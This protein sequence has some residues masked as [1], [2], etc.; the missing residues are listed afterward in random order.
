MKTASLRLSG[1]TALV[2]GAAGFIGSHLCER[3]LSLGSRVTGVDNFDDY[4]SPELKKSNASLLQANST[5]RMV[6]A[7]IRDRA[8]MAVLFESEN[9]DFVFHL[10]ARAGVR[11]SIEH[12][13]LYADVNVT[14]TAVMLDL[15]AKAKVGHFVLASSSSVYG[16]QKKTPYSES[17]D[18]RQPIS[19]YA[20]TK[21]S[22]ELLGAT[23]QH[24][25]GLNVSC[26]RYFTVYGP[27]QRPE[28]A[29][30]KFTRCIIEGKPIDVFAQGELCRDFT[31]IEDIVTGTTRIAERPDGYQIVN[32]G[33]SQ[34]ESVNSL[35]SILEDI[36][37]RDAIRNELPMQP[38]DVEQTFADISKARSEYGYE[39]TTPLGFGVAKY[40]EW[41]QQN[42]FEEVADSD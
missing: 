20:A 26:L 10:A 33:N 25:Y 36:L 12:P 30:A 1:S 31:Y 42:L 3:L 11:P 28:M 7:D 35:I 24:L 39:P 4:Y 34:S 15:A 41:A 22:C 32:L 37:G 21:L 5:F 38:G 29:V 27:R 6:E 40:V 16:N 14:G 19:P 23:F 9:Y 13:V 18:V 8:V 2:T 17:D